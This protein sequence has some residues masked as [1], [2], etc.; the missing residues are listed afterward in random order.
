MSWPENRAAYAD[1][2]GHAITADTATNA[3]HATTADAATNAGHATNSDTATSAATAG[4]ASTASTAT[5]ATKALS[6]QG[7]TDGSA[8][9]AGF[10][11]EFVQALLD[12]ASAVTLAN[13]TVSNVLSISLTAGDWDV[14]GSLNFSSTVA[15]VTGGAAGI[16]ATSA[17]LPT[18]GSEV[19][20]GVLSSL[21]TSASGV[22][23][24][25]KRISIA[26]TTTIYAVGR[27][28]FAVGAVKAYGCMSARR[29]R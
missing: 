13:N 8:A 15:T 25:R 4:S 6:M 3:A 18:D 9:A 23:M 16:T 2:A 22:T 14:D 24:P 17:T 28:T 5:T 29:I 10:V 19:C 27:K 1:E 11:G 7:V 26:T 21:L 12:A 20:D